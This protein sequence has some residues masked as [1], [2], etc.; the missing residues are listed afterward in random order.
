MCPNIIFQILLPCSRPMTSHHVTCHVTAMPCASSLSLKRKIKIKIK[1][2]SRKIDKRKRKMLVSKVFH[3]TP[4]FKYVILACLSHIIKAS[5]SSDMSV[6]WIDIWNSQKGF[7][8]MSQTSFSLYFYT[9]WTDFHK[10]SCAG[11]LQI[12]AICTYMG[13]TKVITNN[14]DIRSSVTEKS[15]FANIS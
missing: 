3:N 13:C 14:W 11:K 7:K 2:K 4:L 6:I 10:Q 8:N 12:K 15:P 9:Q 5:S 1:I